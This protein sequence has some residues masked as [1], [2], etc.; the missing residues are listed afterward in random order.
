ME[1]DKYIGRLLDGRYEILEP[2]GTGGM[3]VVYKARCHR[4]NRLVAIKILKD[5]LSKDE[6][7]RNRFHGES[8][9][10]AMLSH[11]NIMSVYDVS[12]HDDADY[13]VM[14]LIDGITLKQY[15]EKKGT[16]NWKE[17]LHFAMQIAKALEH[18]HGRGIVHRDIK[19]HNVMV[20][21]NGSVKVTDFGIARLMSQSNTLTK[22]ALGSVHYISPEQAKG[23]RV[24]NRSDLYSLGV[25]MYEMMTGR[26]PYDGDSPVAVAIQHINGGATMPSVLN[27]NIPGGLEQIIMKCMATDP[28]QRYNSA[29][30]LLYDLEELRQNPGVLFQFGTEAALDEVLKVYPGPASQQPRQPRNTAERVAGVRTDRPAQSGAR[31]AAA[32]PAQT[33]QA[34]RPRPAQPEPRQ[35]QQTERQ[36]KPD[37]RRKAVTTTVVI[38]SAVAVIAII[39][40]LV[41]LFNGGLLGNNNTLVPV[42]QLVGQVYDDLDRTRYPTVE[43]VLAD[44]DYDEE[45]EA[46]V[47]MRQSPE[48]GDNVPLNSKVQVW[49]SMGP[50]AEELNP[51]LERLTG[52]PVEDAKNYISAFNLRPLVQEEFH[53]T[54]AEGLVI[55]AEAAEPEKPL[56][57]GDTIL[58]FVS[59]GKEIKTARVP[60]GL[61]GEKYTDAVTVLKNNG[62]EK[63]T[64]KEEPSLEEKGTVT[65]LSVEPG[66]ETDVT[67]E[68]I[69][70]YSSGEIIEY[71]PN[72]VGLTE[73]QARETLEGKGFKKVSVQEEHSD[74]VAEGRVI[75]SNIVGGDRVDVTTT[76]ILTISKGPKPTEPPA[77]SKPTEPPEVTKSITIALPSD[78]TEEYNLSIEFEEEMV[79]NV[80]LTPDTATYEF[81][82][83]GRGTG[84][85]SIYIDGELL[86]TEKVD[87]GA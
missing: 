84:E 2:I 61:V 28:A 83:T 26:A 15:M 58:L 6:E 59:R 14:E 55:R 22:E 56:E 18:A 29:T 82:L 70:Y 54:I 46:G 34:V 50:E 65:R 23:G 74:S 9:A 72:V 77:T 57:E 49:V 10:V 12:T 87:F 76:I 66:S 21:K 62:F 32:R 13:I 86:R 7:F 35:P 1:N 31:P 37:N 27:P 41:M 8:Q 11:P 80:D 44:Y 73:S 36:E 79:V 85:Y 71:M 38:C 63:V 33:A 53:E 69:V 45:V 24:D 16:L 81:T 20:L 25:V 43:I 60:D 52:R 40:F 68:I 75:R 64:P 42:P 67:T 5:E 48:Y 19:P 17:T 3:A 78:R 4:L 47:I 30:A 39:I 51:Q